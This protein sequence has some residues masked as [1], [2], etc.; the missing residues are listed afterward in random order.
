MR[1]AATRRSEPKPVHNG[2]GGATADS[3][4]AQIDEL[5]ANIEGDS[6]TWDGETGAR[7][8]RRRFRRTRRL[9][10]RIRRM[11]AL[12]RTTALLAAALLA[13]TGIAVGTVYLAAQV[14]G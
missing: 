5:L 9:G 6:R 13:S 11:W 4:D 12:R 2:S 1:R 10:Y 14:L 3:L 7:R 8:R